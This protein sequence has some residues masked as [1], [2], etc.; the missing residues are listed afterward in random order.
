MYGTLP[1]NFWFP[2]IRFPDDCSYVLDFQLALYRSCTVSFMSS[3]QYERTRFNRKNLEMT[4][5]L[6]Q[7]PKQSSYSYIISWPWRFWHNST[8]K[9]FGLHN[10]CPSDLAIWTRLSSLIF[11]RLYT[12]ERNSRL[13]NNARIISNLGFTFCITGP[14]ASLM[15]ASN[16]PRLCLKIDTQPFFLRGA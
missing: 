13:L 8:R 5:S 1:T 2:Q 12:D 9:S 10:I 16:A 14:P 11:R 15:W 4:F 6:F 3:L 7:S